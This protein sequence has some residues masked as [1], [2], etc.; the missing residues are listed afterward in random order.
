M[1][2]VYQET[3]SKGDFKME[4]NL[5]G[6]CINKGVK[7]DGILALGVLQKVDKALTALDI[8]KMGVDVSRTDLRKL[9]ALG[10]I[11]KRT[12]FLRNSGKVY[13]N[14]AKKLIQN[15]GTKVFKYRFKKVA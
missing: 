1:S 5:V 15:K 12:H 6:K 11:S 14:K 10:V 13:Q 4:E 2:P 7:A 8:K 9:V 3:N